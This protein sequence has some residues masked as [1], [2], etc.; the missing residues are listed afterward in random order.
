VGDSFVVS[1]D[2]NTARL[3]D[4]MYPDKWPNAGADFFRAAAGWGW[5]ESLRK[6]HPEEVQTYLDPNS[7]PYELDHMFTDARLHGALTRCDVVEEA[8]IRE[9]SDHA[10]IIAEFGS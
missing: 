5:C 1:G 9:L 2:W 6:N 7:A 3:F 10:P 4:T 8:S